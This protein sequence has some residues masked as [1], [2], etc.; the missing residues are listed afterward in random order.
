MRIRTQD[1]LA[2][3]SLPV[4]ERSLDVV[5]FVEAF[6]HG[7]LEMELYAPR[8]VDRQQPHSRDELYIVVAGHATLEIDGVEH[9]CAPGDAL[10]VPA[11][12]PHRFGRIS[13]DFAT[14][15]IF[16]GEAQA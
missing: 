1:L 15:A 8:G 2:Q 12:T 7:G 4:A 5:R 10:F 3:L 14:W 6:A 13:D 11:R 9:D 16:W